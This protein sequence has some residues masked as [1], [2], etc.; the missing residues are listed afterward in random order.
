VKP[1]ARNKI[2]MLKAIAYLR[3]GELKIMAVLI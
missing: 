1:S 2:V 3:L